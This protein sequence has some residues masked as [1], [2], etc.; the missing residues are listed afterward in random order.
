MFRFFA[1]QPE[2]V[3]IFHC[4]RGRPR[5]GSSTPESYPPGRKVL[6][7]YRV[8]ITTP[9]G[10]LRGGG[11]CLRWMRRATLPCLSRRRLRHLQLPLFFM[12]TTQLPFLGTYFL[13]SYVFLALQTR[14]MTSYL[15]PPPTGDSNPLT[16]R[17]APYPAPVQGVWD[18][19]TVYPSGRHGL[20][21]VVSGLFAQSPRPSA[22]LR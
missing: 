18:A 10:R 22:K 4:L 21:W 13:P 2:D 14:R 7:T 9:S 20:A 5:L 1:W 3:A 17:V 19:E 6:G 15:H 11:Q 8:G 12:A 16:S